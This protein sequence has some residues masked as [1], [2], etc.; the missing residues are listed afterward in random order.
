MRAGVR[1]RRSATGCRFFAGWNFAGE[2][3]GDESLVAE[4]YAGG[5]PMGGDLGSA[6]SSGA[7][8]AF[9]AFAARDP[10]AGRRPSTDC[11]W[12][13][14]GSMPMARCAVRCAPSPASWMAQGARRRC[15]RW[16]ATGSSMPP[17]R[18]TT[19]C[20]LS[21]YPRR[22]GVPTIAQASA[23]RRRRFVVTAAFRRRSS[24]WPGHHPSGIALTNR[25][26]RESRKARGSPKEAAL[27]ECLT[28]TVARAALLPVQ[29]PRCFTGRRISV[30]ARCAA[31]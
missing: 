29:R 16:C 9:V 18:L 5:V 4:G 15:A 7:K 2:L 11:S 3:C 6:P 14:V 24:K 19:T 23:R 1:W 25:N 22:G 27:E 10:A 31:R 13:R 12:S 26:E 8:P 20:G 21:R 17:S 30:S 28:A